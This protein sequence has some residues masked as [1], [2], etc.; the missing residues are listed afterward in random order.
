[1][2]FQRIEKTCVM[3]YSFYYIYINNKNVYKNLYRGSLRFSCMYVN[4][5]KIF[6]FAMF[7]IIRLSYLNHPK[8]G[9]EK[10]YA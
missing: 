3:I 7:W 10:S 6:M 1:M 8:A 9:G 5:P 2:P 4:P